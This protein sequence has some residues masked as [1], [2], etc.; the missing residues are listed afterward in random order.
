MKTNTILVNIEVSL[1]NENLSDI[2]A[3]CFEGGSNYWISKVEI[4]E[5]PLSE[6]ERKNHTYAS[7]Y[8]FTVENGKLKIHID[9]DEGEFKHEGETYV[10]IT[11]E[12]FI[13]GVKRCIEENRI[14]IDLSNK[15]DMLV[16]Y[17][18]DDADC[19]LQYAVFGELIFG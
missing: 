6:I 8:P 13:Q 18:A 14:K 16:D 4:L 19:A 2:L 5:Q 3:T 1:S 9:Q 7:D 12:K 17:D 10:I 11:K 15:K